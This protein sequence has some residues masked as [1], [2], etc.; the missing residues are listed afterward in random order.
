[1]SKIY[2]VSAFSMEPYSH[3]DWPAVAFKSKE[4]A[5]KFVKENNKVY[6]EGYIRWDEEF[7]TEVPCDKDHEDAEFTYGWKYS[8][9][10]TEVELKE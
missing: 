7:G 9:Y 5:E 10:I 4:Q 1:M 6:G 2:V 3:Y 8:S